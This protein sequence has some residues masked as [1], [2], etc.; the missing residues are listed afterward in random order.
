MKSGIC[1]I[2]VEPSGQAAFGRQG[3]RLRAAVFARARDLGHALRWTL[4]GTSGNDSRVAPDIP[5]E[6]DQM[7]APD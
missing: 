3:R 2:L 6:R 5:S 1:D 7:A 4:A